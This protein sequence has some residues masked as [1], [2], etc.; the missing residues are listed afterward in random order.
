MGSPVN[1]FGADAHVDAVALVNAF[2]VP[3]VVHVGVVV[4]A[5]AFEVDVYASVAAFAVVRALG[6]KQ[7]F[8][9]CAASK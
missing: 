6:G 2:E 9:G 4:F 8:L 5:T 7:L 3:A 1:L